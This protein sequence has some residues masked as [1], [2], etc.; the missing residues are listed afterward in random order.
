MPFLTKTGSFL[1][2]TGTA[3]IAVT[4]LGFVPKILFFLDSRQTSAT[5][6]VS[7]P[8]AAEKSIGFATGAAARRAIGG[9]NAGLTQKTITNDVACIATAVAA[10]TVDGLLD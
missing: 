2:S 6:L 3:D 1:S 4:G 5:D 8:L 7:S 9:R 10:G